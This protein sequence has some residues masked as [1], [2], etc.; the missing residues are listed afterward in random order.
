MICPGCNKELTQE[1]VFCPFCGQKLSQDVSVN[2][3]FQNDDAKIYSVVIVEAKSAITLAKLIKN[4]LSVDLQLALKMTEA[5]PLPLYSD[6]SKSEAEEKAEKLASDGIIATVDLTENVKKATPPTP[7]DKKTSSGSG[8]TKTEKI[9]LAKCVGAAGA[10]L[11]FIIAILILVLPLYTV[12]VRQPIE[13]GET[14]VEENRTLL[15]YCVAA[16]KGLISTLSSDSVGA[17][18][19]LYTLIPVLV[20]V[21]TASFLFFVIKM[22][23]PK[24]KQLIASDKSVNKTSA[25]SLA[26]GNKSGLLS[27]VTTL[28]VF[29]I[30]YLG[31]NRIIWGTVITLIVL[32]VVYYAVDGFANRLNQQAI[33]TD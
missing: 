9:K 3:I 31:Y 32:S 11:A 4:T 24:I 13:G 26:K 18:D 33:T 2:E 30:I 20:L 29:L 14:L 10:I 1:S 5:L 6:L 8:A 25:T 21:W 22:G 28:L 23:I 12:T 19:L 16:V 15:S 27:Q 17:L 7:S